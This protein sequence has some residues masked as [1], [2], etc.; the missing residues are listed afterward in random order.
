MSPCPQHHPCPYHP[1]CQIDHHPDPAA[2]HA[3]IMAQLQAMIDQHRWAVQAV[4]G[5]G[6]AHPP[7][8]YT[9]GLT[10]LD[11]PELIVSGLDYIAAGH[12]L[13]ELAE[14]VTAGEQLQDGDWL[15]D[16]AGLPRVALVELSGRASQ[17]FLVF[18]NAYY[19]YVRHRPV[20]ALQVVWS[21]GSGAMPWEPAGA[22]GAWRQQLAFSTERIPRRALPAGRSQE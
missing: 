3:R 2:Y 9:V 15:P 1:H 17:K 4:L 10:A 12:L 21:D 13:N 11:H 16:L 5:D 19:E 14:R 20:R 6:P 22:R 18:A 7:F 8:A